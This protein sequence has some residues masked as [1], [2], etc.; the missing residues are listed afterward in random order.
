MQTPDQGHSEMPE[1][2]P[3]VQ[4]SLDSGSGFTHDPQEMCQVL[5][6]PNAP[7]LLFMVFSLPIR[8]LNFILAHRRGRKIQDSDLVDITLLWGLR[9]SLRGIWIQMNW[10]RKCLR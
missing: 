3:L 4:M 8:F 2:S 7:R 5:L 10:L 6:Y 1:G 9:G